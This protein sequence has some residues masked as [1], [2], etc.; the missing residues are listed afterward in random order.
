M[1]WNHWVVVVVLLCFMLLALRMGVDAAQ[2]AESHQ[3]TII[4]LEAEKTELQGEVAL[5]ER[6]LEPLPYVD[7]LP[8]RWISSNVGYRTNPMGGIEEALHKGYDLVAPEGT[9]VKAAVSG[10]VR[11]HYPPPND[12]YKGD[13]VYGGK[14]VIESDG[15][16]IIYGHFSRTFVTEGDRIE[17]GEV[18]GL[19]GATGMATGPHLHFEVV[20][21]PFKYLEE[22]R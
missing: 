9:P 5:L 10:V 2:R 12:F 21:D 7:P 4:E 17:A 22:R 13:P 19:V 18:I 14:I 8:E 15:L 1:K 16:L 20:V 3:G 11:E 6:K